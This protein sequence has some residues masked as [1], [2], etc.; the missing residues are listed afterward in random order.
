VT[1]ARYRPA[2]ELTPTEYLAERLRRRERKPVAV[3]EDLV[4]QVVGPE[5]RQEIRERSGER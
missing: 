2:W 1:E 3:D 5:T 4:R